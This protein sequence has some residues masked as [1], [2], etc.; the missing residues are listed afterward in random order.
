VTVAVLLLNEQLNRRC[1][2]RYVDENGTEITFKEYVALQR[3]QGVGYPLMETVVP[4]PNGDV[5]IKTMWFGTDFPEND[6]KPFGTARAPDGTDGWSE[7]EQYDTKADALR[8]H[9]RWSAHIG[10]LT[11]LSPEGDVCGWSERS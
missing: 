8:G 7:C 1:D 6:I 5:K 4:T 2:L 9:T 3:A 10:G 11:M